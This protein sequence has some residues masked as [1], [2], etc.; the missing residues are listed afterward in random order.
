[1]KNRA[2]GAQFLK[3]DERKEGRTGGRADRHNEG[4]NRFSK[5]CERT[6]ELHNN[7]GG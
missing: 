5:F 6:Y 7:V 4:N 1:M 2:V 3:V